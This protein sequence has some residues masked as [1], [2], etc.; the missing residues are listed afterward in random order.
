MA[1][2]AKQAQDI[3]NSIAG[4]L[5]MMGRQVEDVIKA[6]GLDMKALAKMSPADAA[7]A[8]HEARTA[9]MFGKPT[10]APGPATPSFSVDRPPAGRIEAASPSSRE[11]ISGAEWS[12]R[13]DSYVQRRA[14][15]VI[16]TLPPELAARVRSGDVEAVYEAVRRSASAP[17]RGRPRKPED[18]IRE[19]AR[20]ADQVAAEG[21][22][23]QFDR[24]TGRQFAD[25]PARQPGLPFDDG[26]D[27][28][29]NMMGVDEG[30]FLGW[31]DPANGAM[32]KALDDYRAERASRDRA[33]RR[34]AAGAAGAAAAAGGAYL[35]SRNDGGVTEAGNPADLQADPVSGSDVTWDIYDRPDPFKPE[36]ETPIHVYKRH[37]FP[38]YTEWQPFD[39]MPVDSIG[40][41][42]PLNPK[43]PAESAVKPTKKPRPTGDLTESGNPAELASAPVAIPFPDMVTSGVRPPAGP[44]DVPTMRLGGNDGV[45]SALAAAATPLTPD[46]EVKPKKKGSLRDPLP[47]DDINTATNPQAAMYQDLINRGFSREQAMLILAERDP[48][49]QGIM[50]GAR[51]PAEERDARTA[52]WEQRDAEARGTPPNSPVRTEPYS[53][54]S[55][56]TTMVDGVRVPI[57]LNSVG[58]PLGAG[59]RQYYRL[60]DVTAAQQAEHD[61]RLDAQ[62]SQSAQ[63]DLANYGTR[64]LFQY[65]RDKDGNLI[66]GRGVA[67]PTT[68]IPNDPALAMEEDG[69]FGIEA[70]ERKHSPLTPQE[71]T[72]QQNLGRRR[73]M[74]YRQAEQRAMMR[75]RTSGKSDAMVAGNRD[76]VIR[77]AQA[78]QNPLEYMGRDDINDWQ[79]MAA[80]E[81]M[82]RVPQ[83]MTPLGAEAVGAANAMRVMNAQEFGAGM[84]GDIVR[85]R[86]HQ[87][88][89]N[90]AVAMANEVAGSY[91]RGWDGAYDPADVEQ[92]R[93]AVDARFPGMGVAA[94]AHI[95]PRA[96]RRPAEDAGNSG[97][98]PA[99]GSHGPGWDWSWLFG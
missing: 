37:F 81:T 92:I 4:S 14:R 50:A 55:A 53:P 87:E 28:D 10:S 8:V 34:L 63:E 13:P 60:G 59:D 40:K 96:A 65:R 93:A 54:F 35:L 61:A 95:R 67:I 1:G 36:P 82:L 72:Q 41:P 11:P 45:D 76:A 30:S 88:Q 47:E 79:R 83:T 84:N 39:R 7:R 56:P 24:A 85:Q 43:P 26:P 51:S 71:V 46:A 16:D 44:S 12:R 94:T 31:N 33:G 25:A 80:A 97:A 86:A 29:I 22:A 74:E 58:N 21:I 2:R 20:P 9:K 57:V 89:M 69:G 15:E 68:G 98:A 73:D 75:P 99:S 27:A 42:L 70:P 3:I 91:R 78:R 52:A 19:L 32:R 66:P 64:Q 5:G 23:G 90:A 77:R 38:D 18:A 62:L 48:G 6:A 49:M 17:R